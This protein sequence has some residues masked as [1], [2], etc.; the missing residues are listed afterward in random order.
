MTFQCIWCLRTIEVSS[1]CQ[2]QG[3]AVLCKGCCQCCSRNG[4]GVIFVPK[5]PLHPRGA[6]IEYLQAVEEEVS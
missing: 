3:E 6:R 1:L 2:G 4:H 5:Q